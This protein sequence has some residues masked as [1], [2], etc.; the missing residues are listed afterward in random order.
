[1]IKGK[2]EEEYENLVKYCEIVKVENLGSFIY[3]EWSDPIKLY[4]NPVFKRLFICYNACKAR[5]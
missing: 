2:D 1:M 4:G 5:F 3:I